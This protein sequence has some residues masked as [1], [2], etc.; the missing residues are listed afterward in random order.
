MASPARKSPDPHSKAKWS[1]RE[2]LEVMDAVDRQGLTPRV[3]AGALSR[4]LGR[5]VTRDAVLGLVH[6]ISR[7]HEATT[8]ACSRPENCDGGMPKRWWAS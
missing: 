7:A 1:D 4:T 8:C 2:I 3:V 6:R 5:K